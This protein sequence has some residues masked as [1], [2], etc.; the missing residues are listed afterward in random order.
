MAGPDEWLSHS[1]HIGQI[2]RSRTNMWVSGSRSISL[3]P[4]YSCIKEN[5]GRSLGKYTGYG[6][7]TA[8]K[9]QD[10][11]NNWTCTVN[12]AKLFKDKNTV[13][14][15]CEYR[16]DSVNKYNTNPWDR[17]QKLFSVTWCWET[18]ETK[19][20]SDDSRG[21]KILDLRWLFAGRWD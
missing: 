1:L 19:M 2:Y 20:R 10:W 18:Q 12:K 8:I 4:A 21:N 14:I 6:L 13:L 3:S 16:S 11:C 15:L 9:T 17:Q 5:E 7:T